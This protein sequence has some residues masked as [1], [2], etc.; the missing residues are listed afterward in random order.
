MDE[1]IWMGAGRPSE[2]YLRAPTEALSRNSILKQGAGSRHGLHAGFGAPP[3]QKVGSCK[4]YQALQHC[5]GGSYRRT[6][7]QASAASTEHTHTDTQ[8]HRHTHTH[9]LVSP[10]LCPQEG[11]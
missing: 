3:V 11:S 5:R 10:W 9:T 8:T 6:L 7:G 2:V 4:L 1:T